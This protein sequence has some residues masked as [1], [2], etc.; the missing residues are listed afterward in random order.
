MRR[1]R[2]GAGVRWIRGGDE[3][4]VMGGMRKQG[5]SRRG[6][7]LGRD[8]LWVWD[9]SAGQTDRVIVNDLFNNISPVSIPE[10]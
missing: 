6:G 9:R 8:T 5:L 2:K 10:R 3:R 1:R 4:E 7:L